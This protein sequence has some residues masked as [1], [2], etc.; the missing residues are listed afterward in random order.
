MKVAGRSHAVRTRRAL[1]EMRRLREELAAHGVSLSTI[2]EDC[3]ALR[4]LAHSDGD[5]RRGE[6]ARMGRGS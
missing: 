2:L 3:E 1:A 6:P 4:E 5:G